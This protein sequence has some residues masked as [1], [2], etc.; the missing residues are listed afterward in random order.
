[1]KTTVGRKVGLQDEWLQLLVLALDGEHVLET[2]KSHVHILDAK[3]IKE[4]HGVELFVGLLCSVCKDGVTVQ[5]GTSQRRDCLRNMEE[6][7]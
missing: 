1:M 3:H 4:R 6:F 5:D 2:M 7:L